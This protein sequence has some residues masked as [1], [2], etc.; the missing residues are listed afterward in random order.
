MKRYLLLLLT[1]FVALSASAVRYSAGDTVSADYLR[2]HG[3]RE[4]FAV[5]PISDAVFRRMQGRSYGKSCTTPR[6]ELRYLTCLHTTADGHSVVGEMVL[7]KRI[8]DK[9]LDILRQLYDAHYPIECM[10]LVDD[11]D[12]SDERSM[13]ANNSSAFNFRYISGTKQ[14]SKHGLGL[15]ID[16][17]PLYNP[18]VKT[19]TTTQNGKKITRT[20]AEPAAGKRYADRTKNFPYKI[21]RNDLCCRLFREAG[22]V[23]GGNWS[24][25]KDYQ[26][27]EIP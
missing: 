4:F 27:F 6:S 14:V 3:S 5:Q 20:I 24:H 16:I 10:R 2:R 9:V 11:Y 1:A 13:A 22:F 15:A 17:N 23:W 18:M 25:S 19:R 26:H 12:A 21:T 8:A 7:N